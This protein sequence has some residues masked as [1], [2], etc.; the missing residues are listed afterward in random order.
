MARARNR[1]AVTL[2]LVGGLGLGLVSA[3]W[4]AAAG[5]SIPDLTATAAAAGKTE[6]MPLS[7]IRPGMKGHAMTVFY[8]STPERFEIEIIDVVPDYLPRQ[9]AILFRSP[10][11]G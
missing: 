6:I 1:N 5:V 10:I 7:E 9:D 8:G 11:L 4:F 3:A 2:G